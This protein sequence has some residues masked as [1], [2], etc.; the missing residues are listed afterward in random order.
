MKVIDENQLEIRLSLVQF[1]LIFPIVDR[2]IGINHKKT[3]P[4]RRISTPTKKKKI[5]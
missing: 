2:Q 5:F 4:D 1:G 3:N